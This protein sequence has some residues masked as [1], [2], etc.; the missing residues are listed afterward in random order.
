[1]DSLHRGS[2]RAQTTRYNRPVSKSMGSGQSDFLMAQSWWRSGN[3][4]WLT[5]SMIAAVT[6]GSALL[7]TDFHSPPRFDG[8]GYAVLAESLASGRGYR[9]IDRPGSPRHAHFPQVTRSRLPHSGAWPGVRSRPRT[10]CRLYVSL[11]GPSWPGD[12]FDAWSARGSPRCSALRWESTGSGGEL[13][14]RFSPSLCSCSSLRQRSWLG[15]KWRERAEPWQ[16]YKLVCSSAR[17]F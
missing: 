1:M 15:H 7:N 2:F 8:A 14:D 4:P 10:G 13:P 12:G 6:L 11:E 17:A 16:Q 3:N 9:E 5:G